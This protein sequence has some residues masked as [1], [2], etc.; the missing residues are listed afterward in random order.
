MIVISPEQWVT[1]F[2]FFL[3]KFFWGLFCFV[4]F[5]CFGF[6]SCTRMTQMIIRKKNNTTLSEQLI[7]LLTSDS[8]IFVFVFRLPEGAHQ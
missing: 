3:I 6:F 1:P 7:C 4:L 2:I 8:I 5:V